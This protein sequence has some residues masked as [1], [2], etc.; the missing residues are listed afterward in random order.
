MQD[1]HT[2]YTQP[3]TQIRDNLRSSST[4]SVRVRMRVD[5]PIVKAIKNVLYLLGLPGTE[6]V[7]RSRSCSAWR[8][9]RVVWSVLLFSLNYTLFLLS[10]SC[11]GKSIS[12]QPSLTNCYVMDME[13]KINC[14]NEKGLRSLDC[15]R[16]L[17]FKTTRLIYLYSTSQQ[18]LNSELHIS[19]QPTNL[20]N[21]KTR[22][23][24]CRVNRSSP[25][26]CM[27][28]VP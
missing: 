23:P 5:V 22:P 25:H 7:F 8:H 6:E 12:T 27:Q 3:H 16:T 20:E 13:E 10:W 24:W 1:F 18:Q 15:G 26:S 11:W 14:Y 21:R 19:Q 2:N 28:A 4:G 17:F 9:L